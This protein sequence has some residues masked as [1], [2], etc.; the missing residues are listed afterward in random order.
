[1]SWA[2]V[3]PPIRDVLSFAAGLGI[4][5]YEQLT[6]LVNLDLLLVASGLC[7]YPGAIAAISLLRGKGETPHTPEPSSPSPPSSSQSLS[8]PS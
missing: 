6:L 3:W 2:K 5:V 1:M 4:I 8:S 7:G